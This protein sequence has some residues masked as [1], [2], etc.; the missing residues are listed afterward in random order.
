MCIPT[1]D[2]RLIRRTR[3]MPPMIDYDP[4]RWLDHLFDVEGSMLREIVGRVSLCT[5]WAAAVVAFHVFVRPVGTSLVVHTLVGIVLG[6]LL[7]FRTNASYDRY[8]EG[9]R[10]WGAIV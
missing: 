6:L 2:P 4:H 1:A 10:Q 3:P 7:V 8:W 5:V 9:R